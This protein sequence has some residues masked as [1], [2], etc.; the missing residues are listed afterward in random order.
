EAMA[1]GLPVVTSDLEA[2][3]EVAGKG[4]LFVRRGDVEGI[5]DALKKLL[6]SKSLRRRLGE[7][8]LKKARRY[9]KKVVLPGYLHL[10]QRV[11][12]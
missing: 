1:A 8:N 4:A 2:L 3:R 9:D 10:Y 11:A 7:V 6:R 12:R 5:A